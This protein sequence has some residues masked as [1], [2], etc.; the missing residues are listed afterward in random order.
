M[1]DAFLIQAGDLLDSLII[2]N[3]STIS[4]MSAVKLLSL[5]L[6]HDEVFEQLKR[7][8]I[9]DAVQ[10]EICELGDAH[11]IYFKS[12]PLMSYSMLQSMNL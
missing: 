12:P 4:K 9:N 10:A 11:C 7:E 2:N 6:E 5:L 3:E 1:I 8:L